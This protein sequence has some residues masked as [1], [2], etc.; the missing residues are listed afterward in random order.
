VSQEPL[1]SEVVTRGSQVT[2]S[3]STGK[4]DKVTTTLSLN[5][6]A[7]AVGSFRIDTWIQGNKVDSKVLQRAELTKEFPITVVGTEKQN[8]TV[9]VT[10]TKT[11]K[12]IRYTEFEYDFST[13]NTGAT[14]FIDTDAFVKSATVET[15][16][17]T[18]TSTTDTSVVT[19]TNPLDTQPND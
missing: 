13:K 6:P 12:T 11:N 10:S 2:I 3:V 4:I 9:E 16:P 19:T 1:K 8:V 15:T 18:T 17:T 7:N 14:L 5:I